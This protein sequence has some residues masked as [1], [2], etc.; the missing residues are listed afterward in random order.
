M[1]W[2]LWKLECYFEANQAGVLKPPLGALPAF[3]RGGPR[4][5]AGFLQLENVGAYECFQPLCLIITLCRAKTGVR[6]A[7]S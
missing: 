2:H 5:K 1:T 4:V 7:R 6:Q 3:W